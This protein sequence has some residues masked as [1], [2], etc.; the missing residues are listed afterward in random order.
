MSASVLEAEPSS[1]PEPE[2]LPS[3]APVAEPEPSPE[4]GLVSELRQGIPLE[5]E[6]EQLSDMDGS[7]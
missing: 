3:S 4:A 7:E 1:L 5:E 6:T 2:A